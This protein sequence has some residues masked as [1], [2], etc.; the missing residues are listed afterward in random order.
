VRL[1]EI[2]YEDINDEYETRTKYGFLIEDEDAMSERNLATL[3]EATQFHPARTNG[4]FSVLVAMFNYMIGNTDWSPVFFHNV[5]LM[6]TQDALYYTVPYD[7][8]FSGVVNARYATVDPSLPIRRST[9][10]LY[11]GFCR[12]ELV[13]E[14]AV[15]KFNDTRDDI[16]SLYEDFGAVGYEDFDADDA[17]KTLEF[18]EKFYEV[19]DDPDEFEDKILDDCRDMSTG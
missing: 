6:R 1:V 11:R 3:E 9:Q 13:Y 4:D 5:K 16:Q 10:R 18:Y 7:F 14:P 12:E 2:T 8:D 19:V 17:K 15:A